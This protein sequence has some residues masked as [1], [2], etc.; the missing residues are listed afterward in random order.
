L[1]TI[2]NL[3]AKI[4]LS[5]GAFMRSADD[6]S[7][8][9]DKLEASLNK[10]VGKAKP[11]FDALGAVAN[12]A[13][14]SVDKLGAVG[15]VVG[16]ALATGV[17]AA[18]VAVA[19]LGAAAAA[20]GVTLGTLVAKSVKQAFVDI[21]ATSKFADTVGVS[22]ESLVTMEYAAK[23]VGVSTDDLR[24]AIGG[25]SVHLGAASS[26]S[27]AARDAFDRLGLSGKALASLPLE[28]A[29][30]KIGDALSKLP[31]GA[32]QASAA[33]GI[34]GDSAAKILP[35]LN[36]TTE[37]LRRAAEESKK[38]GLQFSS[39]NADKIELAN[40]SFSKMQDVLTGLGRQIAIQIAPAIIAMGKELEEAFKSAPS[41]VD[42]VST[43]VEYLAKGI[44]HVI[45]Q[46]QKWRSVFKN[47]AV[48]GGEAIVTL[49]Q[50]I[51]KLLEAAAELPDELG[52]DKFRQALENSES[53]LEDFQRKINALD[54][55]AIGDRYANNTGAVD[56][57]FKR[58]RDGANKAAADLDKNKNR[59]TLAAINPNKALFDKAASIIEEGRK[60]IEVFHE[61]LE[62]LD[63]MLD[64]GAL[65]WD[66]YA[67]A[68]A[69]AVGELEKANNMQSTARAPGLNKDTV[70]AQSAINQFELRTRNEERREKP[71]ERLQRVMEE[72]NRI[73][74]L[75]LEQER[76]IA[77]AVQD[78]LGEQVGF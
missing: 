17:G 21:P 66:Q 56:E 22:T 24:S 5:T 59:L 73:A 54:I 70:A 48:T 25:L 45:D 44:A 65:T 34:F 6:V 39:L 36:G 49:V 13:G 57:F 35:L 7:A 31:S 14:K 32:S 46:L 4:T 67:R 42:A 10:G 16:P 20:V 27:L 75:Q 60:P 61:R 15:A 52:G 1:P 74:N 76:K 64:K 77:Q 37:Q 47:L 12:D 62:Q 11:S 50:G 8:R 23:R 41:I 2:A 33:Y 26:G 69:R 40:R 55:S 38:A 51:Q 71:E 53:N 43:G 72:G 29:L 78:E 63:V 3:N 28:S 9:G 18:V 19:A 58:L 30:A 68:V